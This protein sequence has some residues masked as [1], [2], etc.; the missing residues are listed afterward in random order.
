MTSQKM[1]VRRAAATTLFA[2]ALTLCGALEAR[3]GGFAIDV[4]APPA[5]EARY[6]DAVLLVRPVGCH[7]PGATVKATAEGI[8]NGQRKS[9]PLTL[10]SVARDNSAVKATRHAFETFALKRQWPAQ[11]AWVLAITATAPPQTHNGQTYRAQ[12]HVLVELKPGGAVR[13]AAATGSKDSRQGITLRW[14]N[15]KDPA[16][17]VEAALKRL[18]SAA[19]AAKTA[20]K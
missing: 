19:G 10:T 16:A 15:G 1:S 11:G 9:I 7:G 6:K 12:C 8:V 18:T 3:A 13:T 5:S 2:L 14:L 17:E 20:A 4:E